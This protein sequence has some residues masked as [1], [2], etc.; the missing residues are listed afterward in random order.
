M[1]WTAYVAAAVASPGVYLL[2]PPGWHSWF[3]TAVAVAATSGMMAGIRVN[4]PSRKGPWVLL[5]GGTGM[6]VAG[7]LVWAYYEHVLVEPLPLPSMGDLFFLM[8]YPLQI[9][10]LL[11]MIRLGQP[12]RDRAALLDSVILVLGASVVVW[13][14]VISPFV[15]DA[16]LSIVQLLVS[17]AYPICDLVLFTLL[18][19]FLLSRGLRRNLSFWLLICSIG[20]LLASDMTWSVMLLQG[21]FQ[22]GSPVYIGWLVSLLVIAAAGLHPSMR[23]LVEPATPGAPTLSRPRLA[24]LTCAALT[25]P[26]LTLFVPPAGHDAIV[27]AVFAI[28]LVCLVILRMYGLTVDVAQYQ[29]MEQLKNE[30]ISVVSHELRTPL[31]SIRGSLGLLAGGALGPMPDKAQRMLEIA[32]TNT[33]RLV[34]LINDVLDIEKIRSGTV[35]LERQ[36]CQA[37]EL[38]QHSVDEMR[39]LA[40][41]S[42]IELRSDIEP[43]GVCADP[44]RIVQTLTNLISNAVKFSPPGSTVHIGLQRQGHQAVFTVTDQGRGIPADKIETIFD[45]FQQVDASDARQQGGTGLGLA[46]CRTLVDQHGGRIWADSALGQG[47]RFSFTLPAL[48]ENAGTPVQSSTCGRTI[49]VVDDDPSVLEVVSAILH[50]GGYQSLAASSAEE[51]MATAVEKQPDAILLDILLPRVSGWELLTTLRETPDTANIPVVIL[52]ALAKPEKGAGRGGYIDWVEKPLDE[53]GLFSAL[54]HAVGKPESV[55]RAL[56]VEDDPQL[57]AVLVARL[58]SHKINCVLAAT[59]SRALEIVA[60]G[61]IDLMILDLML[62]DGSGLDVIEDLRNHDHLR[63]LSTVVYTAKDLDPESRALLQQ[64]GAT[65]FTKSRI[66]PDEFDQHLLRLIAHMLPDPRS[67]EPED[68]TGGSTCVTRGK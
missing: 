22:A 59:A 46:I 6:W 12:S 24:F 57:A 15:D 9:T 49:L 29:R 27:I 32:A 4:R 66:T 55:P 7:S 10:G 28:A 1:L 16:S 67:S 38:V 19:R 36:T 63:G 34:R 65:V 60:S 58:E 26:A 14:F 33:D 54:R 17:V 43:V 56:V 30:F 42:Q 51:G 23:N 5:A 31:T 53:R 64:A 11:W 47:S 39:S 62:P 18:A 8:A 45:R 21:T 52:S 20:T 40:S 2:L 61:D 48:P 41:S 35:Q 37:D 3:F 44:D 68:A 25:G 50:K 13:I